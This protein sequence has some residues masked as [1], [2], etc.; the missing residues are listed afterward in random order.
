MDKKKITVIG[1]GTMGAGI[2]QRASQS[3]FEVSLLDTKDEFIEKGFVEIK[4]TLEKGV[5]LKKVT[6][7]QIT[8][9]IENIH[10]TT[11]PKKAVDGTSLVI[12]AIFEDVKVKSDLFSQMDKLCE[13]EVV[14]ASNTSSLSITELA[15]STKREDRFGGLHFFYPS[16]IN[17]L[18]EV[19]AGDKTSS[20][21]VDLLMKI[22]RSMGKTPIFVKDSPGF[23][24]NRFFVPWLNEACKIL[25]EDVTNIPTIDEAVMDAFK[26]G[27]GPFKLMNVTGIPIAYHSQDSLYKGLGKFYKPSERLKN[28]FE[29]KEQWDLSGEVQSNKIKVVK[30]R[31][32]GVVFGVSCQLVEEEVASREDT[33]RG[34]TMGL[35]WAAGPF[36]MMN[37]VGIEKS[38]KMVSAI[39]KKSKKTFKVPVILKKQAKLKEPWD[40]RTVRISKENNIGIITMNRPEALNAL[41]SKVLSDLKGAICELEQDNEISVVIITGEGKAFVAGADI[42]EMLKKS[43][44]EAREFTYLGQHVFKRIENMSKPVIAAVN[45]VAL[46]GG[47]ELAL[48]CDIIL[49]SKKARFGFPEVGLGIH[50]GFGGTQRL[51]RLIGKAKAKQLI[52][53]ADIFTARQAEHMG[54]VNRVVPQDILL[55]EAKAMAG[56]IAKQAPIAVRQAKSAVNKGYEMDLNTGLDYE[57]ESVSITFSTKDSKEGMKAFTERRKPKFQGK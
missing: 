53:T 13:S 24:V 23:A 4:K 41:N 39:S 19:I 15:K 28:Q 27:M 14:L 52:F 1:A 42:K 17:R 38:H 35:R 21:T 49:A 20:E 50:P 48:A 10:G 26:I 7:E 55:Q 57:A 37:E 51:P 9:I 33:D 8:Q 31:I 12:E 3:G 22:S 56:K 5:K 46:G 25:E 45:G 43:P 36:A 40:L 54:L 44:M 6:D 2:A 34:A 32:L 16:A 29:S 47:A 11:E 30:D 18:V